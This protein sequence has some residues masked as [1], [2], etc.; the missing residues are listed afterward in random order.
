MEE[1][2]QFNT[3]IIIYAVFMGSVYFYPAGGYRSLLFLSSTSCPSLRLS[4]LP[5]GV[6]GGNAEVGDP[7]DRNDNK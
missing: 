2:P 3:R 4:K 7:K 6:P 5:V 1:L